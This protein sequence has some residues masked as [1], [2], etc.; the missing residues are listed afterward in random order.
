MD[1]ARTVFWIVASLSLGLIA[2]SSIGLALLAGTFI[3]DSKKAI[4]VMESEVLAKDVAIGNILGALRGTQVDIGPVG[5]KAPTILW[6]LQESLNAQ[7]TALLSVMQSGYY[8][9]RLSLAAV[10]LVGAIADFN[11]QLHYACKE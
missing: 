6:N 8:D 11:S 7:R 1:K 9:S 5:C 4:T 3:D 2:V 10:Q